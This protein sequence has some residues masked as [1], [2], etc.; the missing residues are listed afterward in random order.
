[1]AELSALR[2]QLAAELRR[3]RNLSGRSGRDMGR[4]SQAKVSRI[5]RGEALPSR[6]EAQEWLDLCVALPQ[7]IERV[8]ALL[9]AAHRETSP[10]GQLLAREQHLQETAADR[11][12]ASV[13]VR[14][15]QPTVVPGLLQTAE[16]ARA[17]LELGHTLD[18][19]AA[20]AARLERQQILHERGRRFE[21]IVGEH[22]LRWSPAERVMDKQI[23]RLIALAGLDSVRLS[24]LPD[25]ANDLIA[26]N[27]FVLRDPASPEDG[28]TVSIELFH[29]QQVLSDPGD[30]AQYELV[31]RHLNDSAAHGEDALELLRK[32][33]DR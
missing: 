11:E 24:V 7:D 23:E 31:W 28:P 14:N 19:V 2:R 12:R 17:V 5:E 6:P 33:A 16:Y 1:M 25:D 9:E 4:M 8:M 29:G 30:V 21:F 22:A 3:I 32:I 27:A 18:P 13:K 26:W 20:L 15:F 10:W